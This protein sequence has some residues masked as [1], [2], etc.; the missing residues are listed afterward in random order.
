MLHCRRPTLV[1]VECRY[2][3]PLPV[4]TFLICVVKH[5]PFVVKPVQMLREVFDVAVDTCR[6]G[7]GCSAYNRRPLFLLGMTCSTKVMPMD[8]ALATSLLSRSSSRMS[9]ALHVDRR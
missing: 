4:I 9:P 7:A 1:G 2:S 6:Y 3:T 5:Q 8:F